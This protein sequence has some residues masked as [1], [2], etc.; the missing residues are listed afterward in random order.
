MRWFIVNADYHPFLADLY[1]T[2]PDL[3]DRP[4]AQQMRAR[5]ATL[6]GVADFYSRNLRRLGHAAFDATIN[7]RY[8]QSAWARQHGLNDDLDALPVETGVRQAH[9]ATTPYRFL[10]PTARTT[11][12]QREPWYDILRAQIDDFRPDVLLVQCPEWLSPEFLRD[13]RA[14]VRAVIA[15]HPATSIDGIEWDEY[16]LVCSSFRPTVAALAARGIPCAHH[17]LGFEPAILDR[18]RRAEPAEVVFIGSFF[19]VHAS[20]VRWLESVCERCPQVAVYSDDVSRLAPDSPIRRA[21]RGSAR[22]RRMFEVLAG[23]QLALNHHGDVGPGAN[24]LRLFEATGVGAALLTDDKPDLADLFEPDLECLRYRDADECVHWIERC[25][26]DADFRAAIARAG[27]RRTLTTHTWL[28]R[29]R[30]LDEI[31]RTRL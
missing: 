2:Q 7:N 13:L 28:H 17:R 11:P 20:R 10:P 25:R 22:G 15:Q 23:A 31:I 24:N 29:M 30:E 27:Q 14:R 12:E 16:D 18:L 4:F 8:A 5:M 1:A 19:D 9:R 26:L 3:A 6:F 21:W